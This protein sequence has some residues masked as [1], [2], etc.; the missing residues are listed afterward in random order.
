MAF[1]NLY[2]NIDFQAGNKM[3]MAKQQQFAQMLGMGMQAAQ[4]SADRKLKERQME[5]KSQQV[6]LK[7]LS[8]NA[9]MKAKMGMP[10][11]PKEQAALEVRA[12]TSAPVV[13]TDAYGNQ[14]VRE[15]GWAGM[16]GQTQGINP[17]A[18]KRLPV[19][20][21]TQGIM[22]EVG[23]SA[24]YEDLSG[25]GGGERPMPPSD[26]RLSV[27]DLQNVPQMD[28]P[29]LGGNIPFQEPRD[30]VSDGVSPIDDGGYIAPE[31]FGAKGEVMTEDFKKNV[32]TAQAKADIQF[33]KEQMVSEKGRE[34]VTNTITKTMSDLR[35]LNDKLLAK[36]AVRNNDAG[37]INNLK[38][39]Y[40][41]T[42]VGEQTSKV[43]APEISS[44][45]QEYE[46]KRDSVIPSYIAYFDI[47]ATVVDTEEMQKRILQSFG[48]P[49]LSYEVNKAALDNMAVQF[50]LPQA[51]E[52]QQPTAQP[53]N[54]WGIK[55]K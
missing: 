22:P 21:T 4:A 46:T 33:R 13:Y 35:E 54:G 19:A 41:T 2:G 49:S 3:D 6:D 24:I 31:H 11:T 16:G 14:V 30:V 26:M 48:D 42:W 8:E 15:S 55:R 38:N 27:D 20:N 17:N 40:G 29:Q 36:Q 39:L 51:E 18:R 23:Q 44:L 52:K 32:A 7:S 10:L 34:K 28:M 45:R 43:T 53:T 12:Q 1:E 25:L 37:V 47:P 50:N 5:I 9:A